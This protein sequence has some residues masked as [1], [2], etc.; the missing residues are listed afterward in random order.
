MI[1]LDEYKEYLINYHI[2]NI[3][4]IEENKNKRTE[5]LSGHYSDKYLQKV[6][7]NTYDFVKDI[8]ASD[9][10]QDGYCIFDADEN[11]Q[12]SIYLNTHGG[13]DSDK[14]FIDL[15][16]RYISEYILKQVFG[17]YFCIYLKIEEI[18]YDVDEDIVGIMYQYS[19]YMQQFP[20]NMDE[21]KE[22]LFGKTKGL[23][24]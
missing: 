19:L 18:D 9:T 24:R 12:S 22:N 10:I 11:S 16:G 5:Y 3:D 7:D 23:R 14:I 8:F 21:I 20:K 4:S 17:N 6:I 2:F 13:Y 1:S 15:Q